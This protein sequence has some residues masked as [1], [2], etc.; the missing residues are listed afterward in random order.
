MTTS[1]FDIDIQRKPP[2]VVSF[3]G[4]FSIARQNCMKHIT[5][6]F[7]YDTETHKPYDELQNQWKLIKAAY[8][9][10]DGD[11][12]L[13][14]RSGKKKFMPNTPQEAKLIFRGCGK[15]QMQKIPVQEHVM[16]Q[17]QV[18]LHTTILIFILNIWFFSP[19][20][21]ELYCISISLWLTRI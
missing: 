14:L 17:T 13:L 16:Y 2:Y 12:Q 1:N 10:R 9:A 11:F 18:A 20:F 4:C 5:V 8:D 15:K 3:D 21:F 7:Q 6:M 19:F